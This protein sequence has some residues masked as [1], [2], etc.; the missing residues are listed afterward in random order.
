MSRCCTARYRNESFQSQ[1]NRTLPPPRRVIPDHSKRHRTQSELGAR[2][3][4][5]DHIGTPSTSGTF[6]VLLALAEQCLQ[7]SSTI[8]SLPSPFTTEKVQ[9][10]CPAAALKS[11]SGGAEVGFRRVV[12]RDD[13][14][15]VNHRSRRRGRTPLWMRF[16]ALLA[17]AARFPRLLSPEP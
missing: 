15:L 10:G 12:A 9:P 6:P 8:A 17:V 2:E 4:A 7:L 5:A 16:S 13:D 1:G 3:P 11:P 14:V